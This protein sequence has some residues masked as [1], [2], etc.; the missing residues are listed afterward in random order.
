VIGYFDSYN[1]PDRQIIIGCR[2]VVGNVTLT[3][4]RCIVTHNSLVITPRNKREL[5]FYYL[6]RN[7]NLGA[8]VGGSAQPQITITDLERLDILMPD[9]KLQDRFESLVDGIEQKRLVI[10]YENQK[11]AAL[12]D[13]LLP[14]LMSGEVRV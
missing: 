11:L 10:F 4:P 3:L 1:F 5:F 6:L 14:K 13:L 8:V 2:G 9:E 12:R 7:Q